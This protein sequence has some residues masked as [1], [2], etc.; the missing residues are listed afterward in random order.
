MTYYCHTKYVKRPHI[1]CSD[2][3]AQGRPPNPVGLGEGGGAMHGNTGSTGRGRC[4]L[5]PWDL[6]CPIP[7][8]ILRAHQAEVGPVRWTPNEST[9][10][11]AAPSRNTSPLRNLEGNHLF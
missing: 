6:R 1:S 3:N 7:G 8:G 10:V 4:P 9:Y 2:N 5:A 11:W